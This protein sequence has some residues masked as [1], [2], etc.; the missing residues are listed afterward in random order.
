MS[1]LQI[2]TGS[3]EQTIDLAEK[4]GRNLRGTEVIELV[5]DL[6]GGKT[7]FVKGLAK[8][9]GSLDQVQSPTFTISRIYAS[10]VL[11]IHHFDLYRLN[12]PGIIKLE[13]AESMQGK[14][15]V[16]VIEWADTIQDI[17]PKAR[18]R[19]FIQT[20]GDTSREF[21]IKLS[22][23]LEYLLIGARH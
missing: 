15:I 16:T 18:M 10:R 23:E 17:L 11:E 2:A 3:L 22:E 7:Q 4:I 19:V 12:D 20:T 9:I 8:G 5:S 21:T 1:Q 6:G 13:L 14:D